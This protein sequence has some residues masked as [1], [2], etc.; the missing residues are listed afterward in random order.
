MM[1]SLVATMALTSFLLA[2]SGGVSDEK[3]KQEVQQRQDAQRQEIETKKSNL[4]T[5]HDVKKD[6]EKSV[7]EKT[8]EKEAKLKE[9]SKKE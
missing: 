9:K 1:K 3:I 8:K 5:K 6:T 2:A 4:D 7:K